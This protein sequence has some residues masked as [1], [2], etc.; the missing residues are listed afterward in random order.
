[1]R[2]RSDQSRGRDPTATSAAAVS[3]KTANRCAPCSPQ[4][5]I[6]ARLNGIIIESGRQ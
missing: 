1:M 3:F 6:C 4:S 2:K 5:R